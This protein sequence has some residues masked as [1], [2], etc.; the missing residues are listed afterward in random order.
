ME[1]G[2]G[3]S[4]EYTLRGLQDNMF[5]VLL[6]LRKDQTAWPYVVNFLVVA[7]VAWKRFWIQNQRYETIC[8]QCISK[9]K[10][11]ELDRTIQNFSVDY[12]EESV[13]A[14]TNW[15]PVYPSAASRAILMQWYREAQERLR[16][17]F[18]RSRVPPAVDI[19]DGEDE[20]DSPDW[21]F[22]EAVLSDASRALAVRW[23]RTARARLQQRDRE[24]GVVIV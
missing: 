21:A 1:Y 12:Y 22:S 23:L 2:F 6:P 10:T 13:E 18:G 8:L 14:E 16:K 4:Q 7:K 9:G 5:H 3:N 15:G 24:Y 19:S 11:K 17:R 20:Q